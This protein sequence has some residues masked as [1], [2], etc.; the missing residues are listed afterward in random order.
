MQNDEVKQILQSHLPDCDIEVTSDGSHFDITVV[1]D[2]FEGLNAVKKQQLV[3][4]GL[5]SQIAN[6][7]VHAINIKTYTC[8]E[9]Q[10]LNGSV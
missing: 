4:A 2:V 5:N 8:S 10:Q 6:G 9:W 3:Y 7:N 1:G